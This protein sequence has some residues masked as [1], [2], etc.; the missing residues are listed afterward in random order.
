MQVKITPFFVCP[1]ACTFA[2]ALDVVVELSVRE[3]R[4]HESVV[5]FNEGS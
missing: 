3:H 2:E 5:I 4:K 1:K